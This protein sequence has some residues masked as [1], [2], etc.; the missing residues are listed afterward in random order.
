MNSTSKRQRIL[1]KLISSKINDDSHTLISPLEDKEKISLKKVKKFIRYIEDNLILRKNILKQKICEE[2]LHVGETIIQID[3]SGNEEYHTVKKRATKIKL[4]E[5]DNCEKK[6]FNIDYYDPEQKY[7]FRIEKNNYFKNAINPDNRIEAYYELSIKNYNSNKDQELNESNLKETKEEAKIESLAKIQLKVKKEVKRT[8]NLKA[9]LPVENKNTENSHNK[10]NLQVKEVWTET[11]N[12]KINNKKGE[13]QR[14]SK[15]LYNQFIIFLNFRKF[16]LIKRLIDHRINSIIKL[17]SYY[18]MAKIRKEILKILENDRNCYMI[19]CKIKFAK[20]VQLKVFFK[21]KTEKWLDFYLCPIRDT[22]VLYIEKHLVQETKYFVNFIADGNTIIDPLYRSDYDKEGNFYNI[23]DFAK[24]EEEKRE[25]EL[26]RDYFYNAQLS[27][28]VYRKNSQ[29]YE[30][31]INTSHNS[32]EKYH[33]SKDDSEIDCPNENNT[34]NDISY[35]KR[36]D[37]LSASVDDFNQPL[38]H[39]DSFT[40]D[41]NSK[42]FRKKNSLISNTSSNSACKKTSFNIT[43]LGIKQIFSQANLLTPKSILKSPS[44]SKPAIPKRVSFGN[45]Q[46]SS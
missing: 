25:K 33:L 11:A 26:E 39:H 44:N 18:K 10:G 16:L 7:E 45:V 3:C 8:S 13:L 29:D 20:N 19:M 14:R 34:C 27:Q 35:K 24:L 23:I 4:F 38:R 15:L 31:N 2:Y 37:N 40:G 9:N 36:K 6:K 32:N 22:Y 42:G 5:Q 46:F 12:S 21:D 30:S 43:K 1:S 17:Q 41:F 28:E